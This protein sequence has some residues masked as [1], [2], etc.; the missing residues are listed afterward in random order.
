MYGENEV[1]QGGGRNIPWKNKA[2]EAP[3]AVGQQYAAHTRVPGPAFRQKDVPAERFGEPLD[4]GG[5]FMVA[6]IED[7]D[8]GVTDQGEDGPVV[9]VRDDSLEAGEIIKGGMEYFLS[10]RNDFAGRNIDGSVRL[11]RCDKLFQFPA[12][13][14]NGFRPVEGF[15]V[16]SHAEEDALPRIFRQLDVADEGGYDV[17]IKKKAA[18]IE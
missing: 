16:I 15:L 12:E 11:L 3:W 2:E 4:A 18:F 5:E 8:G 14:F 17:R 13:L 1:S 7:N 10:V 6:G 9:A